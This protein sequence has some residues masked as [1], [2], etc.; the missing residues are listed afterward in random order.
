[1]GVGALIQVMLPGS[2]LINDEGEFQLQF[3]TW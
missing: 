3:V 2:R 1:M